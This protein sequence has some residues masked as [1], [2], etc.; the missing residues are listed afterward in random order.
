MPDSTKNL[1]KRTDDQILASDEHCVAADKSIAHSRN[2]PLE[3]RVNSLQPPTN[4]SPLRPLRRRPT[5][6]S[7]AEEAPVGGLAYSFAGPSTGISRRWV[8]GSR[9]LRSD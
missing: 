4:S 7:P 3:S 8:F 5:V 2:H 1:L 9:F 6:A